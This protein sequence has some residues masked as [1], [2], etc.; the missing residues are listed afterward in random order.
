[1]GVMSGSF[2]FNRWFPQSLSISVAVGEERAI[3]AVYDKNGIRLE[4]NAWGNIDIVLES[5]AFLNVSGEIWGQ[6]AVVRLNIQELGAQNRR[7]DIPSNP[8]TTNLTVH[9]GRRVEFIWPSDDFPVLQATAVPG[10][11]LHIV[12]DQNTGRFS[13]TGD[14]DLQSGEIYYFQRNFYLRSGRLSFNENEVLVNPRLSLRADLRERVN[15]ESVII[16]MVADNAPLLNFSPR[17]ESTPALSQVEIFSI[18]GQNIIGSGGGQGVQGAFD[19]IASSGMG[20]A[21][22]QMLSF[23]QFE[24]WARNIMGLDV[25]SFR[26]NIVQNMMSQMINPDANFGLL[27]N[28]FDNTTV[29][30]GVYLGPKVFLHGM[31]GLRYTGLGGGDMLFNFRDYTLDLEFGFEVETPFFTLGWSITPQ[32][33][34]NLF[35]NDMAFSISWAMNF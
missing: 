9:T 17:F 4:G 21:L 27:G 23:R 7:D 1:M 8:V 33:W 16:S 30:G 19:A 22:S 25:F 28:Y 26:T 34:E 11:E 3:P 18:L 12:S 32:H 35:V 31:A 20:D 29:Y 15:N 5:N 10:A 6:N 24:N 13:F 2:Q 14:V